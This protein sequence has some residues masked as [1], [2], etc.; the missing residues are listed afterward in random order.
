VFSGINVDPSIYPLVGNLK[1]PVTTI[2]GF[3]LFLFFLFFFFLFFFISGTL[4]RYNFDKIVKLARQINPN[5]KS[6]TFISDFSTSGTVVKGQADQA[7]VEF[8]KK[9][10]RFKIQII[11]IYKKKKYR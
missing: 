7:A 3:F 10:K 9:K 11:S 5:I 2:T 8:S 1:N 4:E 6:M